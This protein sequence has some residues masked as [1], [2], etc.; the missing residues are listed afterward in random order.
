[1]QS[2]SS[3]TLTRYEVSWLLQGREGRVHVHDTQSGK[4]V[5][6]MQLCLHH[7]SRK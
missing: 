4:I 7:T 5:S 1:M 2:S 3:R 6:S